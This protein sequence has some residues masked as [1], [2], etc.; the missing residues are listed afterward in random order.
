MASEATRRAPWKGA[1]RRDR[2]QKSPFSRPKPGRGA[3]WGGFALADGELRLA[4]A[5]SGA[6]ELGSD[7]PGPSPLEVRTARLSPG[8]L[9]AGRLCPLPRDGEGWWRSGDAARLEE[10]RLTVLGRLDGAVQ[11]GGETIFPELL[12]GRLLAAAAAAAL[13]LEAV[14]LLGLPDAE[15]GERL[16]ALVRPGPEAD[17]AA[18]I[19]ALETIT[20]RWWPAERP[21]RW[22]I[23]PFLAPTAA[24]KWER[25]RWRQWLQEAIRAGR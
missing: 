21:R 25:A 24:G 4:A 1:G 12:E 22:L 9:E 10:G 20:A 3:G 8:W 16:V 7:P 5:A 6:P 19:R 2:E 18:L 17:A 15:W 14:L 23:C 11:S 13:P